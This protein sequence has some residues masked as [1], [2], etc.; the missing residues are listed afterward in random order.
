MVEH[1][2][3]HTF[4][5]RKRQTTKVR[6][7]L[8]R[9]TSGP[10]QVV[11]ILTC[12]A[13]L[14]TTSFASSLWS[15]SSPPSL[16]GDCQISQ[17]SEVWIS[18]YCRRKA[19]LFSRNQSTDS[20]PPHHPVIVAG[21]VKI[22]IACTVCNTNRTWC[23]DDTTTK[24]MWTSAVRMFDQPLENWLE[25]PSVYTVS[26][27]TVATTRTISQTARFSPHVRFR[28]CCRRSTQRIDRSRRDAADDTTI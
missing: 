23:P 15:P 26:P 6:T 16:H 28:P 25:I 13:L 21:L 4:T 11:H 7:P 5:Y 12:A 8:P 2:E 18:S 20:P 14:Q 3:R 19:G 1:H 9:N 10:P 24:Q 17:T 27:F 22:Y